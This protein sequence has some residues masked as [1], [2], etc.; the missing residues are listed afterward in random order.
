MGLKLRVSEVISYLDQIN[1]A[2]DR[3]NEGLEEIK[4]GLISFSAAPELTGDAW[5]SAKSYVEAIHVPLLR[6]QIRANDEITTANLQFASL[7]SSK[8]DNE[9]IDEDALQRIIERLERQKQSIQYRN[10]LLV[11]SPSFGTLNAGADNSLNNVITQ[12][13]ELKQEIQSLYDLESS[14]S[15]LYDTALSLLDQVNSGLSVLSSGNCYDSAAGMYSTKKVNLTWARNINSEWKDN[16][17]L[18]FD[19]AKKVQDINDD[20]SLT[21]TEKADR[22]ANIYED[23]LYSLDKVAFDEYWKIREKYGARSPEEIEADRIL[24]D[25]LQAL[26]IDIKAIARSL[27]NHAID[28]S[29]IN[30]IDYFQFM[31]MVNTGK[32]LDLKSRVFEDTNYS[33]WS[34]KWSQDFMEGIND[35]SA[36]YLG[37]YLFGYYGQGTL[38][39][40]GESLK[41]G[42]GVAQIF[43]DAAKGD[44]TKLSWF[45]SHFIIDFDQG[46]ERWKLDGYGDNSEDGEMIQE[47]INDFKKYTNRS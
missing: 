37:N 19:Y 45:A 32:P 12:I 28:V 2:L 23:Y 29:G 9:E 8:I 35:R 18:P 36:D 39:V 47:G 3:K 4:Q 15:G 7:M 43:S 5:K 21:A 38:L 14:C 42:A 22:I 17:V 33:I 20:P 31:A 46:V 11:N 27:G 30:S 6:G 40:G 10:S 34:R 44:M 26:D 1:N 24:G 16:F 41:A 25:K 13:Y